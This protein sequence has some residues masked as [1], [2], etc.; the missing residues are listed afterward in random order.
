[1]SEAPVAGERDQIDP[2]DAY[3]PSPWIAW[4]R[5]HVWKVGMVMG[6]VFVTSM[7]F[8][9]QNHPDPP[10][11]LSELPDVQ[12]TDMHGKPFGPEQMRGKVWVVGFVFTR[13]QSLCPPISQAMLHFEETFV[14]AS[15]IHKDVNMLTITVD[16]E[17][18]T[19]EVLAAYAKKLGAP[20]DDW[21]FVTG[22]KAEIEKF[23]VGGFKLAIGEPGELKD[24]PG[25]F[26]IA[27]S[28]KLALVDR[29]GK[30]RFYAS[31]DPESLNELYHRSFTVLRAEEDTP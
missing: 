10:P 31:T 16:P 17:F 8:A 11:V 14:R 24:Q 9:L 23:V 2:S 26:D 15:R 22:D 13:C 20:E 7:R 29:F 4:L 18:D 19:P 6:L 1:M 21:T 3:V 12:L 27:H 30:V 5:K 28:S 25:V